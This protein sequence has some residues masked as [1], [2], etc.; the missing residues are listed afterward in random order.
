MKR[1]LP[2]RRRL[3][4]ASETGSP[5]PPGFMHNL[6][7]KPLSRRSI[8]RILKTKEI[9]FK[10]LKT[11]ELGLRGTFG[12]TQAQGW[13]ILSLL[14]FN[15]TRG[16]KE[17]TP[18]RGFARGFRPLVF[19]GLEPGALPQARIARAFS[20]L[21]RSPAAWKVHARFAARMG[22]RAFRTL[23]SWETGGSGERRRDRSLISDSRDVAPGQDQAF[24]KRRR[25]TPASPSAPVPRSRS[26]D[27]SGAGAITPPVTS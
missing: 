25:T 15:Y 13:W 18:N 2:P 7:N 16:V 27:G 19:V 26:D 10:I 21:V 20:A 8:C 11:L 6:P 17:A 4:W 1:L 22:A 12:E 24:R 5:T 9:V 23:E 3:V 14:R